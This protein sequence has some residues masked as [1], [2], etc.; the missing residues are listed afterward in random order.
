M[1]GQGCSY[2]SSRSSSRSS[3]SSSSTCDGLRMCRQQQH[4]QDIQMHSS[5]SSWRAAALLGVMMS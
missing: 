4:C 3:S 5:S 2:N 1:K